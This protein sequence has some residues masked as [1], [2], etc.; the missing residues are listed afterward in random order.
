VLCQA[1]WG[2]Y[3]PIWLAKQAADIEG[4]PEVGQIGSDGSHSRS[5]HGHVT[6]LGLASVSVAAQ[7]NLC[8]RESP[9]MVQVS[10]YDTFNW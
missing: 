9:H 3:L 10:E 1:V 4:T 8:R 6:Q 5:L 2:L 7:P